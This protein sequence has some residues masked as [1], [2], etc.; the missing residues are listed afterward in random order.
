MSLVSVG[1]LEKIERFDTVLDTTAT[2]PAMTLS[3]QSLPGSDAGD[4]LFWAAF[5]S[6]S[7][8]QGV[9]TQG[10]GLKTAGNPVETNTFMIYPNPVLGSVV[11]ARVTLNAEARV[12]VEIYNFEGE[13]AFEREYGANPGGLI[14]TP[15]DREI[16]VSGLKSGVYFL[17]MEIDSSG[18]KEKLVKPFAI[19]R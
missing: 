15:F 13:R 11:H 12:L 5:Q 7:T 4:R 1:F 6:S 9:V 17:R 2:S 3:I 14:D 10:V 16:D 8:R 18:G 19:R